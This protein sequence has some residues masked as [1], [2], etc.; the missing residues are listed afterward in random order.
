MSLSEA[1]QID[2]DSV[3]DWYPSAMQLIG[4]VEKHLVRIPEGPA[5]RMNDGQSCFE[6]ETVKN[7]RNRIIE[8]GR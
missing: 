4:G 2:V 1:V 8:S 5:I 7:K 6:Y 3:N